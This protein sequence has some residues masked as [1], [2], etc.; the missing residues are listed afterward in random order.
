MT[1]QEII[2]RMDELGVIAEARMNQTPHNPHLQYAGILWMT[3][4]EASEMLELRLKL[5]SAGQ[6]REEAKAR[7]A[8]KIA[9][10]EAIK[11][12]DIGQES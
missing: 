11:S 3:Q 4:E 2:A 8:Q 1:Q 9:K 12:L 5:P 6:Q 7:I 10:R